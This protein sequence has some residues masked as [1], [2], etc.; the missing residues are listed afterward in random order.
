MIY[1]AI[2]ML[3]FSPIE[4]AKGAV[5][6]IL[7]K[8][9][10]LVACEISDSIDH[11]LKKSY[12]MR[13]LSESFLK[14]VGFYNQKQLLALKKHKGIRNETIYYTLDKII[15]RIKILKHQITLDRQKI[16]TLRREKKC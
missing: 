6:M 5:P 2:I 14:I 16:V 9:K 11:I 8:E 7:S 4:N 13:D 1:L 12:K 10:Q 15:G 3:V